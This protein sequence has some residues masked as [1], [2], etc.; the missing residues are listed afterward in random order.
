M[1]TYI[2]GFRLSHSYI[3]TLHFLW[4]LLL[5][6]SHISLA[7]LCTVWTSEVHSQFMGT[8]W[9]NLLIMDLV[10][11][12][13]GRSYWLITALIHQ[14][15]IFKVKAPVLMCSNNDCNLSFNTSW[16]KTTQMWYYNLLSIFCYC[17]YSQ[18]QQKYKY[19]FRWRHWKK[20][21]WKD[22]LL[23]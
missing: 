7:C 5:Y 17:A 3:I 22:F 11:L 21:L 18:Q 20:E 13:T 23:L 14:W 1:L 9:M 19:V 6:L 15:D 2:F 16:Q 4:L 12:I 10:A 8:L